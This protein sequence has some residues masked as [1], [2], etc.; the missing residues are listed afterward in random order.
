MRAKCGCVGDSTQGLERL[1]E[2]CALTDPE[3]AVARNIALCRR[4]VVNMVE[5]FGL[6]CHTY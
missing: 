2:L 3:F 6:L 1:S 4:A 5:V